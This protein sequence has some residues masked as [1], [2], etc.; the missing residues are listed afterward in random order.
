[1]NSLNDNRLTRRQTI[2]LF[3]AVFLEAWSGLTSTSVTAPVTV[4]TEE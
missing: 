3:G 1:M 2:F 4:K